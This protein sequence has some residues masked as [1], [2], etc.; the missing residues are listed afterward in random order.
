MQYR[1][2]SLLYDHI[3][4]KEH[5]DIEEYFIMKSMTNGEYS[6]KEGENNEWREHILSEEHLERTGKQ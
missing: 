1:K 5:K 3:I 2:K 4:S 6:Y